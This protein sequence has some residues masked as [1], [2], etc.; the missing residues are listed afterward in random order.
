MD[1][2]LLQRNIS[3]SNNVSCHFI[4]HMCTYKVF[5]YHQAT[6]SMIYS[7][8]CKNETEKSIHVSMKH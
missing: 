8:L 6:I 5:I 1:S 4:L 7:K 2:A 3:I